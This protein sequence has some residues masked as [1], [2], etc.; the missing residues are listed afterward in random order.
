MNTPADF[1]DEIVAPTGDASDNFREIHDSPSAIQVINYYFPVEIEIVGALGDSEM[2][3]MAE[4]IY[5][6]L[7]DA[8]QSRD[9]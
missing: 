6:E 5:D 3:Q 1:G 9:V 7:T 2:T 8:L 4:Y